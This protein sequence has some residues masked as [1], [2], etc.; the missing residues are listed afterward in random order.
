M[1]VQNGYN[2][3]RLFLFNGKESITASE[4]KDVDDFRQR[5]LAKKADEHLNI[6]PHASPPP[7]DTRQ[8]KI[9]PLLQ[10]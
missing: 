6:Q 2:A 7:Q 3:T 4:F 5:L 9:L 10:K 1:G 8:K